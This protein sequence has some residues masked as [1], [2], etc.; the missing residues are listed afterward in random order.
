MLHVFQLGHQ[1]GMIISEEFLAPR[2]PPS[3]PQALRVSRHVPISEK[4][5]A[6]ALR[7]S[8]QKRFILWYLQLQKGCFCLFDKV[9]SL[10][11]PGQGYRAPDRSWPSLVNS[12]P[13]H[14]L[15]LTASQEALTLYT[16]WDLPGL[17]TSL[18]CLLANLLSSALLQSVLFP[19]F[20]FP[21]WLRPCFRGFSHCI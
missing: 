3:K 10:S 11:W 2:H 1:S 16:G 6:S 9:L 14:G 20:T 12:V 8:L 21:I 18:G 7:S 15:V 13:I 17:H 19:L 5:L 4:T